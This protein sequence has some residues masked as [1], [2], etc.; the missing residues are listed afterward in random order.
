[1]AIS[2]KYQKNIRGVVAM[3]GNTIAIKTTL[4]TSAIYNTQY[5]DISGTPIGTTNL[6]GAGSIAPFFYLLIPTLNMQNF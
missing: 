2:V 5:M 1:M 4:N 3:T 6:S